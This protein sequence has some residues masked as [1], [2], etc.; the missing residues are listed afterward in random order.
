MEDKDSISFAREGLDEAQNKLIDA[1]LSEIRSC[2]LSLSEPMGKITL[3]ERLECIVNSIRRKDFTN[4][5]IS[6]VKNKYSAFN[7]N[8][9]KKIRENLG[10]TIDKLAD[11]LGFN[12]SGG[13]QINGYENC[14]RI[15]GNPPRGKVPKAYLNWLKENGYNPFN[16]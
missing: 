9:A 3:Q 1:Y 6:Y 11:S 13:V 4:L 10:L 16:L 8:E 15:P 14:R 5:K 7:P 2:Y 12:R